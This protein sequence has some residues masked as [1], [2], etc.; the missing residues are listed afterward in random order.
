MDER[1]VPPGTPGG[2]PGF[3]RGGRRVHAPYRERL[4][5]PEVSSR[6]RVGLAERA[7]RDSLGRPGPDSGDR[8]EAPLRLLERRGRAEVEA[9]GGDL[10]REV[11]DRLKASGEWRP[12]GETT[13]PM[14]D[15]AANRL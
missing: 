11:A 15:R 8:R 13:R 4:A 12:A 14:G 5:D 3:G 1:V 9:A 2:C 7:E 10:P 6:E